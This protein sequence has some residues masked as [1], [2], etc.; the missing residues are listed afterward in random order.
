[1]GINYTCERKRYASGLEFLL[2]YTGDTDPA[3][4]EAAA[5][6]FEQRRA[7][8]LAKAPEDKSDAVYQAM[9]AALKERD[10]FLGRAT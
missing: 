2:D 9:N 3:A 4:C 7:Q 8:C 5:V 6:V 1:M 10:R